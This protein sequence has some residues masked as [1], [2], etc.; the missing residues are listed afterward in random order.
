MI[1]RM[2]RDLEANL[3]ARKYPVRVVY[4]P[5]R[6]LGTRRE[7]FGIRIE[8]DRTS[9]EP[10]DTAH[11]FQRNPRKVMTRTMGVTAKLSATSPVP[12][13]RINEHEALC[14]QLVDAFLVSL[15]EWS[16][17]AKAGDISV[18]EDRYLSDEE[19]DKSEHANGVVYLVRFTI[20]RGVV[21][22]DFD[23]SAL[24]EFAISESINTAVRVSFD[25]QNYEDVL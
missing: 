14:D 13:A 24:P 4:G 3:R 11:G 2:S 6:F 15:V 9:S 25:G 5:E 21:R 18:V 16:T 10:V 1:Y 8:R 17:A 23:G 7:P 12:N 20:Q 19:I 22:R